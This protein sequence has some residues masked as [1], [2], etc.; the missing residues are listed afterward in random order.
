MTTASPVGLL[1]G[2]LAFLG[3]LAAYVVLALNG[4][5]T[6]GFVSALVTLAGVLG[7]GVHVERRTLAQNRQLDQITRQTNGVLDERIRTGS[8]KAVRSV[9]RQLGHNLPPDE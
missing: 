1:A 3:V 2:V 9:M 4:V 8:E 6:N 5:D 7:L